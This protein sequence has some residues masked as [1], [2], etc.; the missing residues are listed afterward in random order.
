MLVLFINVNIVFVVFKVTYDTACSATPIRLRNFV[1]NLIDMSP[2]NTALAKHKFEKFEWIK[3]EG[4]STGKTDG[5]VNKINNNNNTVYIYTCRWFFQCLYI[6]T[7]YIIYLANFANL[8][9][10]CE[11]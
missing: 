5:K 1:A 9:P 10:F 7:V 11:N 2:E 4:K 6:Y 8:D 3:I